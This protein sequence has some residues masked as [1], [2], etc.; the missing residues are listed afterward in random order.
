MIGFAKPGLSD[1]LYMVQKQE[2]FNSMLYVRN[3]NSTKAKLIHK[4]QTHLLV[5]EYVT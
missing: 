5:R 1:D 2:F 3:V 4:R